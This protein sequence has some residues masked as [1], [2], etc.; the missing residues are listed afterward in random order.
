MTTNPS[1]SSS[2]SLPGDSNPT[3][4]QSETQQSNQSSGQSPSNSSQKNNRRKNNRK[5][6]YQNNRKNTK[7]KKKNNG[8][9]GTVPEMNGHV[10]QC[11]SEGPTGN[12]FLR[13]LQELKSYV[14]IQMSKYPHDII[15]ILKHM[16]EC[17]IIKPA[18]P[19][20]KADRTDT[21]IWEKEVDKYVDRREYYKQNKSSMYAIIWT[22]CSL[23]MQA[24]LKSLNEYSLIHK[25]D[26][27]LG[28]LQAIRAI[29]M[30]FESHDY[31]YKAMYV[32]TKKFYNYRQAQY[33]TEAEYMANF[34]DLVDAIIYYGGSLG[35][36]PILVRS[37]L[38]K[39][40]YDM[41]SYDKLPN[42]TRKKLNINYEPGSDEY[43]EATS[44]ARDKFFAMAFLMSSDPRRYKNLIVELDNDHSKGTDN[45][46]VTLTAAYS[47]LVN[48]RAQSFQSGHNAS[49]NDDAS[50]DEV[51]FL[52][53]GSFVP[54]C[55]LCGKKG[56]IAPKC[57]ERNLMEG[58]IQ[59]EII[60]IPHLHQH[61]QRMQFNYS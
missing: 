16:E 46:P 26:N 29:S 58:E 13:T 17:P 44:I 15:Y 41:D 56:H 28:L 39:L 47:L 55:H 27:C 2:T 42:S 12:Q 4:N 18:P 8:F 1:S 49:E 11:Q 19:D 50:D 21:H 25:E 48:Y 37:E 30:K 59:A 35:E 53:S 33:E 61:Q 9:K 5:K 31:L 32:A 34:K 40:G 60:A 14:S 38:V 36:D 3:D 52:S 43:K 24:Q 45:Y 51:L 7:L 23:P 54:T 6:K 10:F 22:Q 20:D 57:P